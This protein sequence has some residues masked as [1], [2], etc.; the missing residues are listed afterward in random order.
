MYVHVYVCVLFVCTF[1]EIC[2]FCTYVV[3]LVNGPTKYEG[4]VE[5][6]YNGNW[7]TVCDD[8]WDS[9]DAQVVCRQLGFGPALTIKNM[10]CSSKI[11]LYNL[12]CTGSESTIEGCSHSGWR[13]Q[14]CGHEE[15]AGL[16]CSASNGNFVTVYACMYCIL[17]YITVLCKSVV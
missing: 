10:E 15:S 2:T 3:R 14:N 16:V 13:I 7:G 1:N 8:G 4:R 11:C 6:H 9:N 12:N 5:V 17:T